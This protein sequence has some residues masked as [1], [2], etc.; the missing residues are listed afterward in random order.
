MR[1]REEREEEKTKKKG[2]RERERE[3]EIKKERVERRLF[4]VMLTTYV[5]PNYYFPQIH[6]VRSLT[7]R[8]S[9]YYL[10]KISIHKGKRS[11]IIND[12]PTYVLQ[13]TKP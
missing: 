3:N 6:E 13:F 5:T 11:L 1:K 8:Y 9:L 4:C 2:E 10:L 7:E 12:Y